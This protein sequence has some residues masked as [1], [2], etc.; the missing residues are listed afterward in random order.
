MDS[1]YQQRFATPHVEL[2]KAKTFPASLSCADV[3][4]RPT[5]MEPDKG[6]I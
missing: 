3:T 6:A 1:E 4:P 5:S 2:K